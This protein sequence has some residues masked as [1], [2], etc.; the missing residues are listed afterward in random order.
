M[1]QKDFSKNQN[2]KYLRIVILRILREQISQI[3][4]IR[5]EF[6]FS[7]TSIGSLQRKETNIL[8]QLLLL[9]ELLAVMQNRLFTDFY[10]LRRQQGSYAND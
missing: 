10:N 4:A 8:R 3:L 7:N 6:F 1:T 2:K 5:D 9:F